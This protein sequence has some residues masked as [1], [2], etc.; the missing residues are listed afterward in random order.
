MTAENFQHRMFLKKLG[1]EPTEQIVAH[2]LELH[3]QA[4]TERLVFRA[5]ARAAADVRR[6]RMTESPKARPNCTTSEAEG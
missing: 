1:V 5:I 4:L 6:S 3:R 2:L